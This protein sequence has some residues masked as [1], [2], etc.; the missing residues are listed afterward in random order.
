MA[1]GVTI[2][3]DVRRALL[4]MRENGKSCIE[5]AQCFRCSRSTVWQVINR[6]KHEGNLLPKPKPGARRATTVR[7]DRI[8]LRLAKREPDLTSKE[9]HERWEQPVSRRTVRRR[10]QNSN[11]R[12]L[13]NLRKPHLNKTQINNRL[14]FCLKHQYWTAEDWAKVVFSD[15]SKIQGLPDGGRRHHWGIPRNK[16]PPNTS[17]IKQ[18]RLLGAVK[19]PVHI[20]MWGSITR[21]GPGEL[22]VI[23][24]R[25]N[26]RAYID[27]LGENLPHDLYFP[28]DDNK[29]FFQQDNAP[30]HTARIVR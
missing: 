22:Q 29:W 15:E 21:D 30:C 24:D 4:F 12:W 28:H 18:R 11:L 10:L 17:Y 6:Y 16:L 7:A 19:H 14:Q 23:E 26:G 9:L 8:L 13:C 3:V 2:N 27:I 25:L 1:K 5:I 20:M